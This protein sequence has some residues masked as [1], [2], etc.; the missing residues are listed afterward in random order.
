MIAG[1]HGPADDPRRQL[2]SVGA[3]PL[4]PPGLTFFHA[5]GARPKAASQPRAFA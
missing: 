5:D 4:A 3:N 2:E 1:P